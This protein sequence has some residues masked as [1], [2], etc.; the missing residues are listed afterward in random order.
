MNQKN[1]INLH[2]TKNR[3]KRLIFRLVQIDFT[4]S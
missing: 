2:Q 1:K 3:S 4:S